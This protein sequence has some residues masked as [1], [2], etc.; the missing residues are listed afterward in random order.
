MCSFLVQVNTEM[1]NKFGERALDI[2]GS[3]AKVCPQDPRGE[4]FMFSMNVFY[5]LNKFTEK[6]PFKLNYFNLG[7]GQRGRGQY[8][9]AHRGSPRHT[10]I[11]GRQPGALHPR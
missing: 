3:R 6:R 1:V 2:V 9:E 10:N 4:L 7:C 5:I 11:Q 8:S